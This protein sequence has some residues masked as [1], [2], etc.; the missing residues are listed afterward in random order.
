MTAHLS[1]GGSQILL[2]SHEEAFHRSAQILQLAIE[3]GTN[4]AVFS[5]EVILRLENVDLEHFAN[6]FK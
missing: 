1:D 2:M 4:Y 3:Q 6:H 5:S